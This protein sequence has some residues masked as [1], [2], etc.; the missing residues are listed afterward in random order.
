MTMH[1]KI[2]KANPSLLVLASFLIVIFLGAIILMFRISAVKGNVA[3]IDALFTATSAVCVTGLV[4]VDTGTAYSTFGQIVILALIQIGGL[5]VMTIS[6]SLFRF[7]GRSVSFKQRM[8][9]QDLFTS[10][11]REDIYGLVKS[12][13]LFTFGTELLGAI[14][15]TVHWAKEMPLPQATYYGVFHSVSAFCN[16]GFCLFSDSLC[17]YNADLLPNL[18]VCGLIVIGGIGFPVLYEIQNRLFRRKEKRGR[19]SI[20]TKSV[21]LTTAI[22]IFGGA[23]LIAFL[24]KDALG[25]LDS[26]SAKLLVP[27]FQSIT[28]RT[29]GFNTMDI[30]A[31]RDS[32]LAFMIFLMYVGAS[33]G[34][35]G[36]GVKTTT[37]ALLWNFAKTKIT[38]QERTTLFRKSVPEEI[39]NRTVSLI[40]ISASMICFVV[41]MLLL[42]PGAPDP[43][44]IL[45]KRGFLAYVF[46]TVSAFG[47]VG[48]STGITSFLTTWGKSWIIVMMIIG[49]VGVLTFSYL[50]VRNGISNR[51][52]YSEEKLMIG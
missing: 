8:I 2:I 49:R 37:L 9:L 38:G 46:E 1:H 10:T 16:A 30:G 42:A 44:G 25:K 23:L 3:W 14:L 27:L 50:F 7:F 18:T 45:E 43:N 28:C 32:T 15:L 5:G 31:L 20:Q 40:V 39:V 47:T 6:V 11:P 41:F 35:C 13:L 48:L 17:R 19:L 29:A 24:E 51:F 52:V 22:L 33:P 36:G 12:I 21:L 26:L 4:T 34:S